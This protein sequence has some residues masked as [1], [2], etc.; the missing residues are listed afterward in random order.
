MERAELSSERHTKEFWSPG[1]IDPASVG[2]PLP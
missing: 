2:C 1:Y